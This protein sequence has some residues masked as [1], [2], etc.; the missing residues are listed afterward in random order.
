MRACF[1]IFL[2]LLGINYLSSQYFL[3]WDITEGGQHTLS[4]AT[5]ELLKTLDSPLTIKAYISSRLP[6][7]LLNA[8]AQTIDMLEEYRIWGKGK[9]RV[10]VLSPDTEEVKREAASCGIARLQLNIIEKD[11][12]S[13]MNA[14]FGICLFYEDRKEVIPFL[15]DVADLEYK[16]SSAIAKM[17]QE[18]KRCSFFLFGEKEEEYRRVKEVAG[19]LFD[20]EWAKDVSGFDADLII[21]LLK[22]KIPSPLLAKLKKVWG[23]KPILLIAQRVCTTKN[24]GVYKKDIG[25]EDFLEERGLRVRED[26]VLD[27]DCAYATFGTR[28]FY[29]TIPYPFWVRAR[30]DKKHPATKEIEGVIFPWTSS[31][32]AGEDFL[33]LIKS[34]PSAWSQ[35]ESFDLSV[36]RVQEAEGEKILAVASKKTPFILIANTSFIKNEFIRQFPS[37]EVFLLSCLEWLALGQG[38]ASIKA[39]HIFYRPIKEVSVAKKRLIK[40]AN[41][42]AASLFVCVFGILHKVVADYRRR[43]RIARL[44][45]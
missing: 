8:R 37:N 38:L 40:W 44:L 22:D 45:G 34:S 17:V 19:R 4:A 18:R 3:R 16:L 21:L 5:K 10:D 36:H 42:F 1:F 30:A 29:Y 28:F 12:A 11:K 35:K 14:Y 39:K 41:T 9:V 20:V 2:L 27:R 43:K 23:E 24:L 31:I 26:L 7:Y 13:L 33:P 15:K 6:S 25:I 32:K